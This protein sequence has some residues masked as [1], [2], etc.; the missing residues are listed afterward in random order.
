M[1]YVWTILLVAAIGGCSQVTI[2]GT[3]NTVN[4]T[5]MV[6]G[7]SATVPVSALPGVP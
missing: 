7:N 3:G 5:I 2:T 6:N 1:R 4:T